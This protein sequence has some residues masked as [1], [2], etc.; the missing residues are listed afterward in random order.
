MKR[1]TCILAATL[2]TLLTA[3]AG[4]IGEVRAETDTLTSAAEAPRSRRTKQRFLPTRQ[5]MDREI[6]KSSSP[7]AAR[8]CSA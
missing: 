2:L 6:N 4:T 5:R 3:S 8:S 1:L 7:T